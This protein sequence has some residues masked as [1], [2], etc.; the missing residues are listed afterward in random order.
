MKDLLLIGSLFLAFIACK[1]EEF[2][3]KKAQDPYQR[4]EH[5]A[6]EKAQYQPRPAKNYQKVVVPAKLKYY[7]QSVDFTKKANQDP[8]KPGNILLVYTGESRS[9]SEVQKR[10]QPNGS[11]NTEHIY[12]QSHIKKYGYPDQPLGDLHHLQ[13]IDSGVNSSRGNLPFTEGH[14][15]T[16]R[17]NK[18]KAWYPGDEYKGDVARMLMY[19]YLRYN[20]P[21]H[22]VSTDGVGLLLKWNAE[23]KVSPLELQRNNEIEKVRGNRNPFIDNPYLA[24]KIFGEVAGHSPENL[25]K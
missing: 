8:K 6:Q 25:W 5:L 10:N 13:Y 2:S 20:L 21:F 12:P 14:G 1:G 3:Q 7:Y 22:H 11:V 16:S 4:I 18:G 23:D 15:V 17:E 24:T 9:K 19:M